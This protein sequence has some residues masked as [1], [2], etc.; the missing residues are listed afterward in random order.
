MLAGARHYGIE[1]REEFWSA[2]AEFLHGLDSA[3]SR[4]QDYAGAIEAQP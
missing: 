1:R 2:V 4:D 3:P